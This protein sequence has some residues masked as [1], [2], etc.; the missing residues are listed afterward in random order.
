M[1]TRVRPSSFSGMVLSVLLA[2]A[3]GVAGCASDTASADAPPTT[4][5]STP[6]VAG[7]TTASPVAASSLTALA[8]AT[9]IPAAPTAIPTNPPEPTATAAPRDV[10]YAPILMYHSFD[11]AKDIYSIRPEVFQAQ[12]EAI[13][14]AGFH[15]VTMK[16]ILAAM[17]DGAPLPD[18]PIV[19]TL[20]DARAT[21]KS[22]IEMLQ[23][24]GFTATLFV[25]SGW[26]ELSKDYIVQLDH[27]GFDI[28]SHTV[29]HANLAQTPDKITEIHEG[30]QTLEQ[31][32]GRPVTGFAYPYGAYRPA[33]VVELKKDGF[34]YALSIRNG[35]ALRRSERYEWPRFLVTNEDPDHLI[36][37][38]NNAL[39][40]AEAGK[41]PPAPSQ[42]G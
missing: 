19:I 39:E 6:T 36:S 27:E 37:R 25:P 30:Q 24:E 28:E 11:N 13:K 16:Q 10:I 9:S 7:S 32:L 3:V 34:V 18:H 22:A 12:L 40:D 23:Q 8:T 20:D 42:F 5:R 21:Q 2:L 38:L 4:A 26:H 35:A 1:S 29:W 14:K 33:D 41:E 17:D 31:W 15:P